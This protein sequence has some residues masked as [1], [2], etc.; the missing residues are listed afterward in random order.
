[1]CYVYKRYLLYVWYLSGKA[2]MRLR[3]LHE[4]SLNIKGD[5]IYASIYILCGRFLVVVILG[6]SLKERPNE[7]KCMTF[8]M[9][10]TTLTISA[11]ER[12]KVMI[13]RCEMMN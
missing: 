5:N 12:R 2:K 8:K 7:L 11:D 13:G 9:V 6:K 1:M 3:I 10:R 4:R